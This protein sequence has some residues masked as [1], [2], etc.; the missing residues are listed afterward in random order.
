MIM[1]PFH[2][3]Y[4]NKAIIILHNVIGTFYDTINILESLVQFA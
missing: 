4:F 3:H 1:F 2:S